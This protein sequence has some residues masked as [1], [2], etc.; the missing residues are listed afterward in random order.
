M[1][2]LPTRR[3]EVDKAQSKVPSKDTERLD[4]PQ[5]RR[6]EEHVSWIGITQGGGKGNISWVVRFI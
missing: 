6:Y 5:Y 2:Y 4:S 1:T 3:H